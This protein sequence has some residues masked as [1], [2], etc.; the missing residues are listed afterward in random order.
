M[1]RSVRHVPASDASSD[2]AA[3]GS[4]VDSTSAEPD[5]PVMTHRQVLEALSGLLLGMFV[6]IL[7]TTVVSTSLPR[8]ISDLNGDQTAF[9]WVVTS[10]LLATTV[11]TPIW[12]KLADI[13]NRKVL[14][15]LSLVLFVVGSGLAGFSQDTSTLILF[16]VFQGLGAGGLTALSQII[17]ADIISPRERGRYMGLFGAVMAVGTVS[18]PLIGGLLTDTVGWRWNF[19]VGVPFA[20][21][22]IILLQLTLR[23]PRSPKRKVRID[24]LGAIL[25]TGGVSLLLIWITMAGSQ[26]EWASWTTVYMVGGAAVLLIATVVT[27]LRAKEPIIP[28]EMFKNRSFTLAVIASISVGVA[29]FGTTVFL[30]QYMQLARGATATQSGLLT[31]PMIGGMLV[32]STV[33]GALITRFGKWKAFM[34]AGS[35]MLTVGIYLMS[36]VEYNTDYLLLSVYMLL[37]GAG[38]GMVMQNLVL[39]VQNA[40]APNL[41]ATA[42]SAVAFFRSL[43]GTIGVSIMG[44]V[45][46][47]TVTS[48]M[49]DQRA[50]IV[51]AVAALGAEGAP[52]AEAIQAGTLPKVSTLPLSL[53]TIIEAIYGQAVADIF[54]IA[55]PLAIITVVAI[56]LLPNKKL[57]TKTT[58]ERLAEQ[59]REAQEYIHD[60]EEVVVDV[61]EAMVGGVR[62]A[63][64]D[65][66]ALPEEQAPRPS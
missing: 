16:R 48:M 22:A 7:A 5:V 35:V 31:L 4:A 9:T 64:E 53:R 32:S 26:F 13:F 57:G 43:G 65:E 11:S 25:L 38:I 19:F 47:A 14:I 60:A 59:E 30:S 41:L 50:A 12:G 29:M 2:A 42:S 46:A 23:L 15:Q 34:V 10:T 20:I 45:L 33:V 63:D 49:V 54:L 56:L 39:V 28:L 1:S 17:M 8:I 52:I 27:E 44:S 6:S 24:Y 21:I 66:Q 58:L 18:G 36:T 51:K 62:F 3:A 55:V 40:V 37:L 61:A